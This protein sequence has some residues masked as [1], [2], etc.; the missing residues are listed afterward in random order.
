MMSSETCSECQ[1]DMTRITVLKDQ[2]RTTM[3]TVVVEGTVALGCFACMR[4]FCIACVQ[5]TMDEAGRF[6]SGDFEN[7]IMVCPA[8]QNR[9]IT[10]AEVLD[11]L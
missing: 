9:S 5:P 11:R 4:K 2:P 7:A 6:M 3:E 8:C 1:R 10:M